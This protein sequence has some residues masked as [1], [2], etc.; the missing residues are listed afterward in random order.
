SCSISFSKSFVLFQ[1]DGLL[2]PSLLSS[3]FLFSSVSHG[4]EEGHGDGLRGGG[5][6]FTK[7][8]FNKRHLSG[9]PRRPN[10][11]TWTHVLLSI[12]S[13]RKANGNFNNRVF[14]GG[15]KDEDGSLVIK[16]V[17]MGDNGRYRCEI[18]NGEEDVEALGVVFPYS[19][20]G[21]R[22][23]LNFEHAEKACA[24]QGAV[25]ASFDQL[26]EAWEDG[27]DWC[28]AGWLNDGTVQYPITKPREPCGGSR[29]GSGLRSYGQRNKKL[30]RFD[31]FCY[32]SKLRGKLKL[33][34]N[35]INFNEAVQACL[36]KDAEI[37]KVGHMF[38]AWKLEE[39]NHCN[40]G[41]LADGSVR[42][43]VSKPRKN[44][45]PTE[46]AVR[47]VGFPDKKKKYGVY[48]FRPEQ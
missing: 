7:L 17:S 47:L 30:S 33:F 42:Y 1:Q 21:G 29:N 5:V 36:G 46:A 40:A 24:D 48:C 3:G 18:Q 13:H 19:P 34:Q 25:V 41:W 23:S 11:G 45:S 6:V 20:H 39:Y 31:V 9:P 8:G 15:S 37:A 10:F 26:Y 35:H 16:N 4:G 43:P 12:S 32:A 2:S 22:Y 14:L 27:L 38:A 28:N 44:C